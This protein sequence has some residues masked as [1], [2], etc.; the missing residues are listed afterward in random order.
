MWPAQK[1]VPECA[2]GELLESTQQ[3][4][5]QQQQHHQQQ[6]QFESNY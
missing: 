3:Q 6:Q 2:K 4:Q 1:F 5:Q